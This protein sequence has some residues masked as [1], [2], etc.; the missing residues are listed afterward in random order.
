MLLLETRAWTSYI[1]TYV[2]IPLF[3]KVQVAATQSRNTLPQVK[4]C[5]LNLTEVKAQTCYKRYSLR[6]RMTPVSVTLLYDIKSDYCWSRILIMSLAE[7]LVLTTFYHFDVLMD[8]IKS[9]FI[10]WSHT[11]YV[12]CRVT[13]HHGSQINAVR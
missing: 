13:C 7:V 9:Y 6:S 1:I 3:I 8:N 12:I 10:N 11:S 5:F 4:S 2:S